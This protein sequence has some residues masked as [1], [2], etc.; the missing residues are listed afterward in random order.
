MTTFLPSLSRIILSGFIFCLVALATHT[1]TAQTADLRLTTLLN[2]AD[3]TYKATMQ[4]RASDANSFSIGTSSVFLTYDPSSL[5]L[6][7]YQSQNFNEATLCGGQALWDVHSFD[8]SNPGLFNL[9]MTLNSS[10]VSCPMITNADWVSIGIITFS[11]QNPDGNP[12]LAF[13]PDFTSFNAVPANN[14]VLQINAG[15]YAGV[16][17]SGVLRC[18]PVCSLSLT[19]STLLSGQ[20]GTAYSQPITATSTASPLTYSVTA[21]SLPSGLT[22]GTSTGV[23]SGTPTTASKASFTLLV[24]D[25]QACSVTTPLSITIDAP[26]TPL[27]GITASAGTCTSVTNAYTITGTISLTNAV[28]S[29]LTVTDGVS[30]AIV[31]VTAGQSSTSFTLANLPSGTGVHTVTVSGPGYSPGSTTYTAPASCTVCSLSLTTAPLAGGLIGT[32]Y[33]QAISASGGTAPFS[34]TVLS[35]TLPAG[36]SLNPTTGNLSGN[37]TT[38]STSTFAVRVT[39]VKACTAVASFSIAV[40][41]PPVCSLS[42]TA[43]PGICTGNVYSLTGTVNLSNAT[44]G[45]LTITDGTQ[46]T[47]VPIT[48]STTS[49]AYS[50]T[51]L[52]TG[53]GTHTVVVILGGCGTFTIPYTAPLP[54]NCPPSEC[55]EI[56]AERIR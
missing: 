22:L 56:S 3:G 36:L 40:T 21:G 15:Q 25:G 8:G 47:T 29:S 13:N 42:A 38:A 19:I 9:T 6:V 5:S 43:V 27:L 26:P 2:C 48:A 45:Q 23:I 33:S 28:A 49:V 41:A 14:G 18:A 10:S 50:F 16:N 35:G 54:C 34:Y 24:T 20:V 51:G 11:V 44:T 7:S 52:L 53:S 30:T 46:S 55:L 12:T 39:D 31:S 32:A 4:I 1:V 17:Q 37:P